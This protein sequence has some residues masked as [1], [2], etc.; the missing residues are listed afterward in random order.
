MMG[1]LYQAEITRKAIDEDGWLHSGDLS[2][3]DNDGFLKVTKRK[4]ELDRH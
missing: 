4:E 3:M 1:Y 2:V